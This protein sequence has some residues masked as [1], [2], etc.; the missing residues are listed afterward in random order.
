[1]YTSIFKYPQLNRF[2]KCVFIK[3]ISLA[4]QQFLKMIIKMST[5]LQIKK[6]NYLQTL[7]E[8]KFLLN[9]LIDQLLIKNPKNVN[10]N[11]C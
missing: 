6:I 5:N 4:T 1:M 9:T 2:S 8:T 10:L 3:F 11:I 7:F